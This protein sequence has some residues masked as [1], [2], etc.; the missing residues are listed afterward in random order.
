MEEDNVLD[1]TDQSL[2]KYKAAGEIANNTLKALLKTIA[3]GKTTTELCSLGNKLIQ[4]QCDGIFNNK[5]T[6]DG[7]P[8]KK[9]VAFPV[10]ISV[11]ECAGNNCPMKTEPGQVLAAGDVV[12]IDLGVH[13]DFYC[14]V[15]GHTVVVG[16]TP[17]A[18]VKGPSADVVLAALHGAQIAYKIIQVGATNQ[19]VTD[20]M[21]KVAEA[22]GVNAVQ[23]VLMH[24]I[25]HGVIDGNNSIILREEQ[26][27]AV[28]EW[29]FEAGRIYTVDVIMS[30]GAGKPI[31]KDARTTVFKRDLARK[32]QLKM[33]ASRALLSE[34]DAKHSPF[35][36]SL[37]QVEDEKHARLGVKECVDHGLF[38]RYPVLFEKPGDL[39][40]QFKYTVLIMPSGVVTL[41][42]GFPV[43]VTQPLVESDKALTPEL[44]EIMAR[45]HADKKAKKKAAGGGDAAV[46]PA[47]Q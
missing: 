28:D 33:Q 1:V 44:A 25:K 9:G 41:L 39:V 21:A 19:Q 10:C 14:A 32:Y 31:E 26:D 11:N 13:I 42:T 40:A 6:A 8:M 30:T 17:E 3:P 36:F 24:Q 5:K 47:A 45:V 37:S 12:K 23:G 35:P 18:K 16:A 7:K 27:Q 46:K 22:Y 34:V 29:A 15:A 2:D 4:T 20:A 38:A 43:D